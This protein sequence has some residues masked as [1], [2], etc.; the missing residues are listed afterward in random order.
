MGGPAYSPKAASWL[1]FPP[2]LNVLGTVTNYKPVR[3]TRVVINLVVMG[4]ILESV[5]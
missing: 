1:D 2:Q 4:A 3:V 5:S